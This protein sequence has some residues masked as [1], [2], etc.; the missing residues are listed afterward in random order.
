MDISFSDHSGR[1]ER[2]FSHSSG[3]TRHQ[4]GEGAHQQVS[5]IDTFPGM[6]SQPLRSS[7][8]EPSQLRDG[9][10]KAPDKP[11][12]RQ[13]VADVANKRGAVKAMAAMFEGEGS[14]LQELSNP[15]SKP[16]SRTQSLISHYS[17]ASPEKSVRSSRSMSTWRH[18]SPRQPSTSS[19]NKPSSRHPSG[20]ISQQ[21]DP[22]LS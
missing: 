5:R 22:T 14:Q 3:L 2:S 9:N 12:A 11:P 20:N 7:A 21:A 16:Q 19:Q 10:A 17:Q 8:A 6:S 1:Q 4:G 15:E 13:S 18:P